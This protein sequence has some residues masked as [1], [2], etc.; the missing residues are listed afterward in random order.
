MEETM[1]NE[2]LIRVRMNELRQK[3]EELDKSTDELAKRLSWVMAVR[4]EPDITELK[5][6][7]SADAPVNLA[8]SIKFVKDEVVRITNK[9]HGLYSRLQF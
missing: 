4:I 3:L 5:Q 8:S 1:T 6:A 7:D 2:P 9:I